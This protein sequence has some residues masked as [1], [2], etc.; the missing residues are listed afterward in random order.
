MAIP[1]FQSIMLPLLRLAGDNKEHSL[2]DAVESLADRMGLSREERTVLLP[3]GRQPIFENRVGWARTYL[4]KAGLL[5]SPRR[6]VFKITSR[7]ND[8][9]QTNPAKIA[10]ST[11]VKYPEFNFFRAMRHEKEP[12]EDVS[13]SSGE[14]S[15]P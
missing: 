6:A 1:D 9:L 15:T 11:L 14:E 2:R 13:P 3:S 5:E 12:E 7:G 10:I 8:M 4:K